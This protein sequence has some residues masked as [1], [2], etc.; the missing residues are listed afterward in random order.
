MFSALFLVGVALVTMNAFMFFD[1]LKYRDRF[2][3]VISTIGVAAGFVTMIST[4]GQPN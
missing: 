1:N 2:G 3:I 4:Y